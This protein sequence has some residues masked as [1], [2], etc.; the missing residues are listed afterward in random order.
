MQRSDVIILCVRGLTQ[1]R[2]W[3]TLPKVPQQSNLGTRLPDLMILTIARRII[4]R[5]RATFWTR[6]TPMPRSRQMIGRSLALVALVGSAGIDVVP[7]TH[8]KPIAVSHELLQ[9][10]SIITPE[11][12]TVDPNNKEEL[13]KY[14]NRHDLSELADAL[15]KEFGVTASHL[16]Q[17]IACTGTV[18]CSVPSADGKRIDT[19]RASGNVALQPNILVTVKHAFQDLYSGQLLPIDKCRLYHY[20]PPYRTLRSRTS[21]AWRPAP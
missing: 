10:A 14:D 4:F 20:T 15:R 11:G 5:S 13:K 3:H 17:L 19:Y 16:T 1:V 2:P 9:Q 18:L 6:R 8:A 21:C 7:L 12:V